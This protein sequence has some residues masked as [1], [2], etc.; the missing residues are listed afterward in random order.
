MNSLN[1]E[2]TDLKYH[3]ENLG[4]FLNWCIKIP[5]SE[6]LNQKLRK[7]KNHGISPYRF[8]NF[9]SENKSNKGTLTAEMV[10]SRL[11]KEGISLSNS[12]ISGFLRS[13]NPKEK[14]F[15]KY[16]DLKLY[17]EIFND[18]DSR[19][20]ALRTARK[21]YCITDRLSHSPLKIKE[22]SNEG[23]NLNNSKISKL[24][25]NIFSLSKSPEEEIPV[26][27][28]T[29][30]NTPRIDNSKE[31]DYANLSRRADLNISRSTFKEK[32]KSLVNGIEELQNKVKRFR[33][34]I[35][36]KSREKMSY[37]DLSK[38]DENAKKMN[39][40]SGILDVINN[41]EN[42]GH[43]GN[44]GFSRTAKIVKSQ[45]L[46]E[47]YEE[48][49]EEEIVYEENPYLKQEVIKEREVI[50]KFE[51]N[52]GNYGDERS[53]INFEENDFF[54]RTKEKH[55]DNRRISFPLELTK[56]QRT[57]LAPLPLRKN[58]SELINKYYLQRE[59]ENQEY[60]DRKFEEVFE[61]ERWFKS[62]NSNSIA[63]KERGDYQYDD[64]DCSDSVNFQSYETPNDPNFTVMEEEEE[65]YTSNETESYITQN[66]E[67]EDYPHDHYPVNPQIHH[68]SKSISKSAQFF[69]NYLREMLEKESNLEQA[70]QVLFSSDKSFTVW[71]IYRM[72]DTSDTGYFTFEDFT[73]FLLNL[74]ISMTE[75]DQDSVI[76][77]FSTYDTKQSYKMDYRQFRNM[78]SYVD[79]N[80]HE[81]KLGKEAN[82]PVENRHTLLNLAKV[83][84]CLIE[85]KRCIEE[86]KK[87]MSDNGVDLS[88]L[89]DE[90]DEFGKG[91]LVKEDF[92]RLLKN[93]N[94]G[95]IELHYEDV[96]LFVKRC[97][98]DRDGRINFR[99]FYLHFSK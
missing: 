76:D 95:F 37:V 31:D 32:A 90:I 56:N 63:M 73:N 29:S 5:N 88:E 14:E 4:S 93:D 51:T 78:L 13:I 33:G 91:Y 83:F 92:S 67:I 79:Y 22:N 3:I 35:L 54:I 55:N 61:S 10:K 12:E 81:D 58:E 66:S 98:L 69:V 39:T 36:N 68:N 27:E 26:G 1:N 34:D 8:F 6:E 80:S 71:R 40:Y 30:K 50:D 89:F 11:E 59:K 57:P 65:N 75:K 24:H 41:D 62:T 16:S 17:F 53:G 21:S 87:E 94:P 20:S 60:N 43:S 19:I 38:T 45:I 85:S 49:Q 2:E 77:L 28:I 47:R 70:K 84:K 97:D 74:G 72:I 82:A 86:S 46:E 52:E 23:E 96:D 9:F 18:A 15:I 99:D 25:L 7:L 42:D 44:K 48:V 64:E